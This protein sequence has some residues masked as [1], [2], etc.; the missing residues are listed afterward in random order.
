MVGTRQAQVTKRARQTERACPDVATD[1]E[2]LMIEGAEV[3]VRRQG[4]LTNKY[5]NRICGT[6]LAAA[7]GTVFNNEQKTHTYTRRYILTRT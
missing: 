1:H 4:D 3:G 2:L 7:G 5:V 6:W